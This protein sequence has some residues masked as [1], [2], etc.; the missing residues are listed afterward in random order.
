MKNTYKIAIAALIAGLFANA[1]A[2]TTTIQT[3]HSAA[4][5]QLTATDYKSVVDAAIAVPGAGYGSTTVA[6]YD[7]I[8]N[9]SLF[10]SYS[11]IAFKSTVNFGVSAANA[12]SWEI[13]SGVDFGRGGAIFVD[14]VALA[15]SGS[16]MWWNHSYGNTAGVFDVT[17]NLSAGNHTLNIYGLEGCCDGTQQAQFKVGN[18]QFTTFSNN[19]GLVAVV[20]EPATYGMMLAGM[21]LLAFTARRKRK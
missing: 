21:G 13:R 14:G 17:L 8:A 3:G 10:G 1:Q 12:G 6:V 7:N 5:P 20:P 16:D 9:Q 18:G 2:S 11:D 19:D 4:G 15:M